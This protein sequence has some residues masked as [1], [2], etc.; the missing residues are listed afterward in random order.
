MKNTLC[1]RNLVT[2]GDTASLSNYLYSGSKYIV[3]SLVKLEFQ[4][5]KLYME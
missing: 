5:G 4:M 2:R 1:D 3:N